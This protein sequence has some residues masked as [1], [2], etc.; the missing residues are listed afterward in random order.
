MKEALFTVG[1]KVRDYEC[2]MQGIVNNAVFQNYLETARHDFLLSRDVDFADLTARG[3]IVIVTRA[4]LDYKK[5]LRSGN[6]FEVTV[7]AEQVSRLKIAFKQTIRLQGC[8]ELVMEAIVYAVA[9]KDFKKP[10][11]PEELK[12]LL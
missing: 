3:I 6:H 10:F 4:E 8:D 12:A 2:D 7:I 5:P 11:F 1:M 9:L